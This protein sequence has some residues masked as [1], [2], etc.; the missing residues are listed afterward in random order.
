MVTGDQGSGARLSPVV[1]DNME[2]DVQQVEVPVTSKGKEK[3]KG[4]S[5]RKGAFT[6][7]EDL[8]IVSGWLNIATD[9]ATGKLQ[10]H[11]QG[12]CM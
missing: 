1:D 2:D 10:L 4:A 8:V 3:K 5:H 6:E 11:C 7:E 9:A 12:G